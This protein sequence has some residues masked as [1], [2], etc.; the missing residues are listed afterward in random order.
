MEDFV[1]PRD[2]RLLFP[3]QLEPLL[4]CHK[5]LLGQFKDRIVS[6]SESHGMVGDIFQQLCSREA[7]NCEFFEMY[8]AYMKEFKVAMKTLAKYEHS[9][10]AFRQELRS[11]QAECDGLSLSAF[12]LTPVQRL[13]RYELL[14]KDLL[15]QAL[16]NR[17]SPYLKEAIDLL[18][19]ELIRLNSSIKSCELACSVARI[20]NNGRRSGSI[21]RLSTRGRLAGKQLAKQL[22]KHLSAVSVED[23]SGGEPRPVNSEMQRPISATKKTMSVSEIRVRKRRGLYTSAENLPG[24]GQRVGEGSGGL[25][26]PMSSMERTSSCIDLVT[27]YDKFPEKKRFSQ[28]VWLMEKIESLPNSPEPSS[29]CSILPRSETEDGAVPSA[30]RASICSVASST[31]GIGSSNSQVEL[32]STLTLTPSRPSSPFT[33][34]PSPSPEDHDSPLSLE[35]TPT[36]PP[37]PTHTTV[38]MPTQPQAASAA[39]MPHRPIIVPRRTG[40]RDPS[41]AQRKWRKRISWAGNFVMPRIIKKKARYVGGASMEHILEGVRVFRSYKDCRT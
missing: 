41:S 1:S 23:L 13:P 18:H 11:Q 32:D 35:S 6:D 12:L 16:D 22:M 38:A 30:S 15:K 25:R 19:E 10:Q 5:G 29:P 17:D 39:T 4:E 2:L 27:D 40:P 33:P 3:C 8:S 24:A 9:S 34:Q 37:T 14:L 28:P 20:R 7:G 26:R 31:S 36:N 21:R